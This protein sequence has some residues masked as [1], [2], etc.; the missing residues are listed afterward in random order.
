MTYHLMLYYIMLYCL[1][2]AMLCYVMLCYDMLENMCMYICISSIS[3]KDG[4]VL[5][6]SHIT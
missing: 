4:M 6:I 1:S 3:R 2:Y 5:Y